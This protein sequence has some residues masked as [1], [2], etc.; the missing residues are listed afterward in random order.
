MA[1]LIGSK[2]ISEERWRWEFK[3]N[4]YGFC[5]GV[6]EAFGRIIGHMALVFVPMKVGER[7]LKG[8]QAVDLM[9]D[10]RF[11][12]QGVFLATGKFLADKSQEKGDCEVWYGFPTN[13]AYFGH[14]KYGW[15]DV[16]EVPILVKAMNVENAFD[17]ISIGTIGNVFLKSYLFRKIGSHILQAILAVNDY[18]SRLLFK[19]F[20][21]T[22]E[23]IKLVRVEYVDNRI[24]TFWNTV[25]K[26]HNIIIARNHNYLNWRYF[27]NP[28]QQ[29]RVLIAE[30]KNKILGYIVLTFK[31][32]H[33]LRKGYIVDI[34]SIDESVAQVLIQMAIDYFIEKK[35]DLGICWMLRNSIYYNIL[36]ANGFVC[37]PSMKAKL[38]ARNSSKNPNPI[39]LRNHRNW[40]I[41]I[42]DSD[43][44]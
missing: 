17:A 4:P 28:H 16:C 6:T 24:N 27:E 26:R 10:P 31:D 40:Y 19:T 30:K 41:T 21:G 36:K 20:V 11:R 23:D 5:I 29:Y 44:I 33:K 2:K 39:L 25:S 12:R 35:V 22:L 43:L 1:K 42:G 14:L 3:S 34:L 9:V 18:L 15:F 38:I 8:S 13:E 7:I 37:F 32:M